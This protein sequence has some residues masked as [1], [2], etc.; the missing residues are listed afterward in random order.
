MYFK[1]YPPMSIVAKLAMSVSIK[2]TFTAND[3]QLYTVSRP[4]EEAA[5][6]LNEALAAAVNAGMTRA[7]V[8]RRM[9]VVMTELREFGAADSEP[10][11][12]LDEVLGHIFPA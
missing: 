5:L 3:W 1:E 11:H 6:K 8:M 2:P 4:C 9:D 12:L 7:Q 10:S